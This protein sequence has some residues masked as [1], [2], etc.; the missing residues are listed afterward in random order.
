MTRM[1]KALQGVLKCTWK[2]SLHYD[3]VKS[4][5]LIFRHTVHVHPTIE[6]LIERQDGYW[7]SV[8]AGSQPR[9]L[10]PPI[11]QC[12]QLELVNLTGGT[13]T[14]WPITIGLELEKPLSRGTFFT[15]LQECSFW[16]WT[17]GPFSSRMSSK[18]ECLD[19]SV[20]DLLQGGTGEHPGWEVCAW[21][22]KTLYKALADTGCGSMLIH[23][24]ED[25]A[26]VGQIRALFGQVQCVPG[27]LNL[28]SWQMC[29]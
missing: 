6:D 13:H 15:C 2:D 18:K 8:M 14:R 16:V 11:P 7:T 4:I 28:M 9:G 25:S 20:C 23:H 17:D 19:F 29:M 22:N 26:L 10:F 3:L 24:V 1:S 21:V 5:C 27:T 12:L